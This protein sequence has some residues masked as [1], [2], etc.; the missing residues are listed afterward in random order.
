MPTTSNSWAGP[1]AA[2]PIWSPTPMSSSSAVPSSMTTSLEP[3]AQR[4]SAGVDR[5]AVRCDQLRLVV[6]DRAGRNLDAV[7]RPHPLELDFRDRRRHGGLALEVEVGALAGDDG[8]GAGVRL[9]EDGVE[10]P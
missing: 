7:D 2:T 10:G 6:A 5:L 9:D 4:P 3:D 8:V 1:S